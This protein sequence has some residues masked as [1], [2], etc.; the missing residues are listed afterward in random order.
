MNSICNERWF[1]ITEKLQRPAWRWIMG[2][3]PFVYAIRGAFG[4]E[5]DPL[6]FAAM[7]APSGLT[8]WRR[9]DEKLK[10]MEIER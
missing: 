8:Y 2:I 3:P 4:A 6:V 9:G 7:C 1:Q 5:F 10:E